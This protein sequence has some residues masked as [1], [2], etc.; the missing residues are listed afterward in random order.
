MIA[1]KEII[2]RAVEFIKEKISPEKIYLFGSY[3][4]GIPTKDSDLDF[5][6]IE[7]TDL[8]KHKRALPLYSLEKTK[9]IGYPIGI[10]FIIYTPEKFERMKK[11]LNSIAGEVLR[12]G[13]LIYAR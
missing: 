8:P 12:T 4:K 7:E 10:D 5:L 13:K 2:D 6:I 9:K 3:A 11:E 1:S